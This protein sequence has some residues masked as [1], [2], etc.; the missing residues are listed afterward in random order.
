MHRQKRELRMIFK[1]IHTPWANVMGIYPQAPARR[2]PLYNGVTSS[3]RSG[4]AH[5]YYQCRNEERDR[6]LEVVKNPN[7]IGCALVEYERQTSMHR[8]KQEVRTILNDNPTLW[9]N[10]MGILPQAPAH[11][12]PLENEGKSS[13]R[14]DVCRDD[15]RDRRLEVV[16]IKTALSYGAGGYTFFFAFQQYS[17]DRFLLLRDACHRRHL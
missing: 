17:Y 1:Y 6:R 16:K 14:S 8:Q 13:I 15:E 9:A 4:L 2:R 11:R 5:N 7:Y 10:V 3:L 12:R